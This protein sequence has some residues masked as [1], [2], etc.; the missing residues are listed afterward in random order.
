M[1]VFTVHSSSLSGCR[2]G[3]EQSRSGR[4]AGRWYS[5]D[6]PMVVM[7]EAP[8]PRL[9]PHPSPVPSSCHGLLHARPTLAL[10]GSSRIWTTAEK[11]VGQSPPTDSSCVLTVGEA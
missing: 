2:C 8:Q 9:P 4:L 1:L 10:D 3:D 7:I 5:C 6:P 11:G